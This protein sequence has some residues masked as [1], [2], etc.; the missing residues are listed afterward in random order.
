MN[1]FENKENRQ[2][3]PEFDHKDHHD[4][5]RY[6]SA[7]APFF[8]KDLIDAL[9]QFDFPTLDS[10]NNGL[11]LRTDVKDLGDKYLMEIEIPGVDKK[12][13][14]IKIKNGYLTV[15]ASVNTVNDEQK[16]NYI[17]KERFS[18]SSSRSWYVGEGLKRE[19]I[20]AKIENGL[21]LIDFPKKTK[22][23]E[24]NEEVSID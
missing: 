6:L 11:T 24:Q 12:D 8:G 3:G 22:E 13:V 9:H 23:A 21:L 10:S 18:G 7:Y 2:H 19:N 4:R 17:C 20:H 5:N 15:K 16:T 14:S 1:D